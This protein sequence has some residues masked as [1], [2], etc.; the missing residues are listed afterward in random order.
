MLQDPSWWTELARALE[1]A[2]QW[3]QRHHTVTTMG[4]WGLKGD[5]LLEGLKR[6][7]K[8]LSCSSK[9]S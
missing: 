5:E 6:E 8:P 1:R 2:S 7:S 3:P 4:L 9:R